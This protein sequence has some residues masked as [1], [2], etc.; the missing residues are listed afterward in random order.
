MST[1]LNQCGLAAIVIA[2]L[3]VV[4]L[5]LFSD[6][7]EAYTGGCVAF[8]GPELGQNTFAGCRCSRVGTPMNNGVRTLDSALYSAQFNQAYEQQRSF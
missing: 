5:Y 2:L 7:K 3:I 6:N 8:P 1:L 4:I